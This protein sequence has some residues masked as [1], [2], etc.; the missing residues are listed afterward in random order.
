MRKCCPESN[1]AAAL[2]ITPAIQLSKA[3]GCKN[4]ADMVQAETNIDDSSMSGFAGD[5]VDGVV[6]NWFNDLKAFGDTFW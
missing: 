4:M 5:Q 3:A 6:E 1:S 2:F